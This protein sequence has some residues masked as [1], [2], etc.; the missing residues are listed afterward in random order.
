M[1]QY[2]SNGSWIAAAENRTNDNKSCSKND[3]STITYDY[4]GNPLWLGHSGIKNLINKVSV[5]WKHYGCIVQLYVF[6]IISVSRTFSEKTS[7]KQEQIHWDAC[8]TY[9]DDHVDTHWFGRNIRPIS[10]TSEECTVSPLLSEYSEQVISQ[11]V[12]MQPHIQ[13][14]WGRSLYLYIWSNIM[15]CQKDGEDF[16][17]P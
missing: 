4:L 11:Y 3:T 1:I 13:W 15:V 5:A 17:K 14:N 12:Q 16:N 6:H 10:F 7:S 8:S 9:M 2:P